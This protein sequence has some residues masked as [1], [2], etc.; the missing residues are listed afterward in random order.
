LSAS[1]TIHGGPAAGETEL[2][3]RGS[4]ARAFPAAHT[5]NNPV[6]AKASKT[7]FDFVIAGFPV[8]GERATKNRYSGQLHH[9]LEYWS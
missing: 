5:N 1:G 9:R 3:A 7:M 2:D 6:V 8:T 4:A